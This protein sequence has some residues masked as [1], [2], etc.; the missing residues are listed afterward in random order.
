MALVTAE[1]RIKERVHD[2]Q[3]KAG[4]DHAGAHR[5]DVGVVV[6]ARGLGGEAIA[7]QSGADA[8]ELVGNNGDTDARAADDDAALA[9]AALDRAGHLGGIVRIVDGIGAVGAKV[10][11]LQATLVQVRLDLLEKLVAAVITTQSNHFLSFPRGWARAA[12]APAQATPHGT[13]SR[14]RMRPRTA[15]SRLEHLRRINPVYKI[16]ASSLLESSLSKLLT[17]E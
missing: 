6:L 4:A 14:P 10:L 16:R 3:R 7:A 17:R 2:L 5:K 9:L 13:T 8:L 12:E 11:V 1:R 15:A